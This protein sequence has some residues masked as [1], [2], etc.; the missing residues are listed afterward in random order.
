[1]DDSQSYA[2]LFSFIETYAPVGFK[3]IDPG[4]S[5]MVELENFTEMNNQ[6]FLIGDLIQM[7]YLH[8]SNRSI[9]M[10]GIDPHIISPYHFFEATHPDDMQRHSLGRAKL[11]K[12]AHDL[13]IAERGFALL[14][15]NIR[16]RNAE[17]VYTNLLMQI[18][19][20]FSTIPYKSV[21][22]LKIH[23]NIDWYK[24]MKSD[25]HYY[26]GNKLSNFRYP[27]EELLKESLPFSDREFEI[28]R[29]IESGLTSEQIAE[30]IFLS[31]HTVNT[32]RRNILLKTGKETM[33][34][35]IYD[36]MER[37]VL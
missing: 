27:D 30:K 11:F 24:Q 5:L 6:F 25:Y 32:H 8:V 23:T 19:L 17:G 21:F 37:G 36:L 22:F 1:M 7:S 2:L 28:I 35:L 20:Y 34:E 15:T 31:V 12:L 13:F 26:V 4:D 29:L 18:Y 16:I 3:G 9:P 10:I 14:S 33:P